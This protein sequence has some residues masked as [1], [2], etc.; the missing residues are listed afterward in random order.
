MNQKRNSSDEQWTRF[1]RYSK[2]E[3]MVV[4]QILKRGVK[5]RR[6]IR[7]MKLVPR[8]LFVPDYLQDEAYSDIPLPI[9]RGQTI[10]QPY[11][12]AL[13]LEL[14]ELKGEEKVLDVGSG[15][16]YTSVLLG[17]LAKRVY[18]ID[19]EEKLV[20]RALSVLARLPVNNVYM[21]VGDGFKGWMEKAPFDAILVGAAPGKT[22]EALLEQ[23]K[24]KGRLV[25]PIGRHYQDLFQ[26]VRQGNEYVK[27][28]IAP[29]RFVPL[30]L[31]SK[32]EED[33]NEAVV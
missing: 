12:V 5:D 9:G 8:H 11:V 1:G 2:R 3:K 4:H 30:R 18:A 26:I 15:S 13:M 16:G 20:A 25:I 24:D 29:V 28:K 19:I 23:L 22:P 21:K 31:P 27:K 17:L 32:D 14:M 7:A 33:K 10:S 6:V